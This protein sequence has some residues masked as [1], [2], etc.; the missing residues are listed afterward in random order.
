MAKAGDD[1]NPRTCIV[2]REAGDAAELIRFVVAPDGA[3][4]AD[5]KRRLPGRGVWVASRRSIV[6]EAV[7]KRLFA[8]GFKC[9]VRASE[10]LG[11]DIDA[12]LMG[13]AL[14]ALSLARKAGLVITGFAKVES[15]LR[16]RKAA[17]L[18]DATDGAEDGVRKLSQAVHAASLDG[19]AAP[20]TKSIFTSL[21]MDLAL[22]G[23]NVVHAAVIPG[24][25]CRNLIQ[26]IERLERYRG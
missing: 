26:R 22:G 13:E 7:R 23:H 17:L 9:E 3:V 16:S 24:G 19:A 21:Q 5:L 2:T 14:G 25:A 11:A 1:M 6:D 10:T 8:R 15:T 4:V 12:L 20:V 18:L